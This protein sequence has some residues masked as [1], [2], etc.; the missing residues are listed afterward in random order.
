MPDT[1]FDAL[2]YRHVGPVG[3][4]VPAVV[5]VPGDPKI[6]YAGSASGGIFKSIDGGHQWRPIFDDVPAASIGSLAVAPSD[7]NVVWVGTGEG[8]IRSNISVGLG[9]YRSTDGGE[10]WNRVGLEDAGRI[11]RIVVDPRDP[12]RA[13]ACVQGHGYGPQPIRGVHRT[14]DGGATWTEVLA[15]DDATGCSDLAFD[16]TNPRILYAGSWTFTMSTF[17]RTSGGDGSALWMSR[18]GGDSWS[19]LGPTGDAT[20]LP[21]GPWGK[22]AVG[23]SADDPRKVY[24]LIE[25]SSNVDFHDPGDYPGTL[26]RSDDRGGSWTM[27]SADNVLHQR[28][29]YYSRLVV[30]PDDA[31]EVDFFAPRHTRSRDGGRSTV[32]VGS[33]YDHHDAWIDPE[34][35]D[36]MI[37]G[38]DGGVSISVDR[39]EHWFQPRLPV[40]Q[41]YHVNVDD[42]VPYFLYGNRQDG[43]AMRGP[44]NTLTGGP[45]PIGAWRSIGGCEVGFAVPEPGNPDR[46]WSGCYD[47]IL[48]IWHA[49]TGQVRNVSVWPEAIESWPGE[50]LRYRFHWTF[51]IEISP[52]DPKRVYVGSQ[53]VHRTEDHGHTWAEISPDLTHDRVEDKQRTGGLTLDDAGPTLG[54]SVFDLAE[55]PIEAGQLWAGTNDGRVQLS[56]DH[57]ET[58]TDTAPALPAAPTGATVSNVEP[59]RHTNGVAYLTLDAHRENDFAPHVYKTADFGASWTKIVDG[60]P[61]PERD[62]EVVLGWAH[63]V[64]EDPVVP[65]LL[66]LGTEGGVFVSTDDGGSWQAMQ[67]NLPP[68]PVHWLVVQ[69]HF[70]DL[71]VGTY[72]RGFW[73]L[74]DLTP[75]QHLAAH[76]VTAPAILPPRPAYRFR[77]R[78]DV[79]QQPDDPVAGTN[80][81]WGASLHVLLPEAADGDVDPTAFELDVVDSAGRV[82][83]TF[84]ELPSDPGLHRIYWEFFHDE[85]TEPKLRTKPHGN[86]KIALPDRGWR[87]LPDGGNL[88]GFALPGTYALRLT[89]DG[90]T[91]SEATLEV[92]ADPNT[93]ATAA[94]LEA[95][96]ELTEQLVDLAERS[97]TLIN[98]A[99][100]LRAQ[101]VDLGAR[102]AVLDLDEDSP[103]ESDEPADDSEAA[104]EAEV[105]T[106]IA[107]RIDALDEAV[108]EVEGRFFDL[109]LTNAGQDTLR[110]KRLIWAKLGQL[111]W[112]VQRGDFAPTASQRQVHALLAE[113]IEAAEADFGRLLDEDVPA[114][115]DHLETA[116]L[117]SPIVDPA[118]GVAESTP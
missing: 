89:A 84:D 74:D 12:R 64:V 42:Q 91:V 33:G 106:D 31:W 82:V 40:A 88:A 37:V 32:N 75:L 112:H 20:G 46:V 69:D 36:R 27:I 96:F 67:S 118:F 101:L 111:Y 116:G 30:S 21:D 43:D 95:Q 60:L 71:V 110:W 29:L 113:R 63:C 104:S 56:R 53:V 18:D 24:A 35:P 13:W 19:R 114:L 54:P 94:D 28:P 68:A 80:P 117:D 70:Q 45:I 4:R 93:T 98:E 86:S 57:G 39:G 100:W 6:Y 76:E 14:D 26:W 59:S 22:V 77:G 83:K 50:D 73:I 34:D 85:T 52:H 81:R 38:H 5:G 115:R 87:P 11:P 51:P 25:T 1:L 47:G 108:R 97:A 8:F 78:D 72:G 103:V 10:T 49:D 23:L 7:P 16:P 66:Y 90:D 79:Q 2:E 92:L 105:G 58:W 15:L 9:V 55:S 48:D 107:S 62:G 17:G 3:N 44:S 41:M 99:E 61:A 102:I 109:R 65:G